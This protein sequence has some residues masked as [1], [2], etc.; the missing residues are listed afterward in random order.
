MADEELEPRERVR[1]GARV[2]VG[3]AAAAFALAVTFGA[4]ARQEGWGILLGGWP[5]WARRSPAG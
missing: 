4:T 1:A 2:G 5:R 3:L